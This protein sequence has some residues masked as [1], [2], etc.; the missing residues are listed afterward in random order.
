ML[1]ML[2]NVPFGQDKL[3]VKKWQV[4]ELRSKKRKE[5]HYDVYFLLNHLS[6][7]S[8][9][10]FDLYLTTINLD[11]FRYGIRSQMLWL[12]SPGKPISQFH[13]CLYGSSGLVREQHTAKLKYNS[14]NTHQDTLCNILTPEFLICHR[15]NHLLL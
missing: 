8:E 11:I 4:V 7:I 10:V 15:N 3:A 1:I 5:R 12:N 14:I 9:I 13:R 2:M 6:M